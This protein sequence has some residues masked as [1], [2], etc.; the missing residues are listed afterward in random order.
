MRLSASSVFETNPSSITIYHGSPNEIIA[1]YGKGKTKNDYGLA[2][3]CTEDEYQ[4]KLW[5][6]SKTGSGYVYKYT[7]NT[8]G[9]K[10]LKINEDDVL[11]WLAILM[12]NRELSDLSDSGEVNLNL[13][14]NKYLTVDVNEYDIIVGYRADDSY[15]RFATSFIEGTLTYEYLVKAIKLGNLGYQVA[16]KSKEAFRRLDLKG[17]YFLESDKLKT[18]YSNRDRAA[19]NTYSDYAKRVAYDRARL[20]NKVNDVYAFLGDDV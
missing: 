16:I 7:I 4:A 14:L 13:F 2:F 5:A 11:L 17:D 9:L 12:S 6:V 10:I 18:E 1:E 8:D 20:R 19:R 15:F 3:Y